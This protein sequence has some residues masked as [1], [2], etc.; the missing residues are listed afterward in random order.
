MRRRRELRGVLQRFADP[1][2]ER[3][4]LRAERAERGRAIRALIV[5][6]A[7]TLFSYIVLN[8]IYFPRE[9]VIA[10]TAAAGALIALMLGFFG[11]TRTRFYLDH[12]WIDLP[13]FVALG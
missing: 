13:V 2:L 7:A 4:F 6:A 3:A 9:G 1:E 8:P 5:V 11:L 12:P 10:Y